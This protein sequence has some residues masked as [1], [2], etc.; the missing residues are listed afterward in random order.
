MKNGTDSPYECRMIIALIFASFFDALD[1]LL[2]IPL[3]TA[4]IFEYISINPS[5]DQSGV[6][7]SFWTKYCRNR[8]DD[9]DR[10]NVSCVVANGR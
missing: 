3:F 4:E 6:P 7:P 8:Y 2:D 5:S 1:I 10:T 9:T